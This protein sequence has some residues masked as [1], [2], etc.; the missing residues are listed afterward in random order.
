M[1]T[2]AEFDLLPGEMDVLLALAKTEDMRMGDM[3]QKMAI[4]PPNATRLV[5]Q[6]EAKGLVRRARSQT[7]N[8][9]VLVCLT[10]RG[11]S[12]DR[13]CGQKLEAALRA[14]VD[15]V[16]NEA[17]RE[18]LRALLNRICDTGSA[19]DIDRKPT[20]GWAAQN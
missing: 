9:V 15:A 5:K 16:L 1:R 20:P 8:R 6:M 19:K 10:E 14:S 11:A 3:A 4:S 13:A 7:S 12:V 2:A 17:D 18:R